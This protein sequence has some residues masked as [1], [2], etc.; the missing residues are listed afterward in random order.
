MYRM[1]HQ[2]IPLLQVFDNTTNIYNYNGLFAFLGRT[3]VYFM[4]NESNLVQHTDLVEALEDQPRFILR[5]PSD[6]LHMY[7]MSNRSLASHG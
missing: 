1:Q 7:P 6:V 5:L 2:D 3:L 4:N